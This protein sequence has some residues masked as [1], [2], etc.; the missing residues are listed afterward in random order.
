MPT[1]KSKNS[2]AELIS[3]RGK[4]HGD[5]HHQAVCS[6]QLKGIIYRYGAELH[7]TQFEALDMIAVK[8]SRIL[9]GNPKEPD[10]WDDIA[11]YALL[12]KGGHE[13]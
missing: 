11:G 7:A 8:M 1:H 4:T 5:W 2:P 13:K 10:H 3:E 6:R 9:C 12:G